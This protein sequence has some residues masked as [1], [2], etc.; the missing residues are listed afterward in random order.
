MESLKSILRYLA[1]LVLLQFR[2]AEVKFKLIHV[3]E[4]NRKSPMKLSAA[5]LFDVDG[6]LS[7]SFR[8]GYEATNVVLRK[9]KVSDISEEAYHAGTKYTTPRRMAWHVTGD[10][11]NPVGEELVIILLQ[12]FQCLIA[13][14]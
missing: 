8:L 2:F 9:N 6:T 3:L 4:P 14:H 12:K 10:P 7:D 5:V 11:D 13:F 1:L